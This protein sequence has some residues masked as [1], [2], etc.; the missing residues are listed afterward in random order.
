MPNN[1]NYEDDLIF[2]LEETCKKLCT[3][4]KAPNETQDLPMLRFAVKNEKTRVS[5]QE[6]RFCMVSVLEKSRLFLY[7]VETPTEQSYSFQQTGIHGTRKAQTDLSLLDSENNVIIN[8]EFKAHSSKPE[9]YNKD[10]EKLYRENKTGIWF[11]IIENANS[12][13]IPKVQKKISDALKFVP[14]EIKRKYNDTVNAEFLY[15]V[16]CLLNS[17]KFCIHKLSIKDKSILHEEF[18]KVTGACLGINILQ[19]NDFDLYK[20]R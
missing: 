8:I 1:I 10:F 19:G 13:T 7:S 5:E 2:I 11:Q 16:F 14:N 4:Y 18:Q 17:G 20:E 12:G 6:A 3:L 15:L 9:S